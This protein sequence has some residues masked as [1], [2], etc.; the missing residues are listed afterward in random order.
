[1]EEYTCCKKD[2]RGVMA[3]WPFGKWKFDGL[4]LIG[5]YMHHLLLYEA[6]R[7]AHTV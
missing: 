1:M 7:L 6:V 3:P 5:N 4:K 2:R